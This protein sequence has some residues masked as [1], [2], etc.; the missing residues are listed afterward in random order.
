MAH[1]PMLMYQGTVSDGRDF[2]YSGFKNQAMFGGYNYAF[3]KK[4]TKTLVGRV[5]S[6]LSP[7]C[8]TIE[9]MWDVLGRRLRKRQW[10]PNIFKN[11]VRELTVVLREEW[12]RIPRYILR[13]LCDSMRLRLDAVVVS[14]ARIVKVLSE[15]V[16][17]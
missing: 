14:H 15:G 3:L 1:F 13:S 8:N 9:H 11:N 16:K 12:A 5:L 17:H 4:M 10:Q 6:I 7:N 2:S